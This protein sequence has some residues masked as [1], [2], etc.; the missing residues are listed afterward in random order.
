M[1]CLGFSRE[2]RSRRNQ[3]RMRSRFTPTG[4]QFLEKPFPCVYELLDR[5]MGMKKAGEPVRQAVMS[6]G[7]QV[8]D[9]S[10]FPGPRQE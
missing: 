7:E 4:I 6:F 9:P 3:F 5:C 1:S 2:Q 10:P 8:G